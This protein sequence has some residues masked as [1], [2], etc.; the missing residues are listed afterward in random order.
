M[1]FKQQ[2][3]LQKLILLGH[4]L[5]YIKFMLLSGSV[6]NKTFTRK[7]ARAKFIRSNKDSSNSKD[8]NVSKQNFYPII[9]L[10]IVF[11]LPESGLAAF[12]ESIPKKFGH[13]P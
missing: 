4:L 1:E 10:W 13:W 3:Q 12:E 7:F 9:F 8:E 2:H 5:Q 11:N 6:D